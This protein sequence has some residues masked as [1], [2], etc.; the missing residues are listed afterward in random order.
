MIVY[1]APNLIPNQNSHININWYNRTYEYGKVFSDTTTYWTAEMDYFK[2]D[3]FRKLMA[4]SF[5]LLIRP[6]NLF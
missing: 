3:I 6:Q 1:W 4:V 5:V 2:T